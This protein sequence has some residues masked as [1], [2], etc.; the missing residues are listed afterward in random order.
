MLSLVVEGRLGDEIVSSRYG[1]FFDWASTSPLSEP[2]RRA[3]DD[4]IATA[5][6]TVDPPS[7][8]RAATSALDSLR[9]DLCLLLHADQG[10]AVVLGRSVSELM[11]LV[12]HGLPFAAKRRELVVT[13][14]DHPASTMAWVTVSHARQLRIRVAPSTPLGEVDLEW[15]HENVTERTAAMCVTHVSHLHGTRQPLKQIIELARAEGA[16]TIVDGAQAVG[17]IDVDLQELDADVYLGV[18]RKALLAP[19]GTAFLV[20][21]RQL[22]DRLQPL[23]LSTRA[24]R[25]SQSTSSELGITLAP[26]PER[27]EFNVPDLAGLHALHGSVSALLRIGVRAV[28][29]H[30]RSLLPVIV[31]SLAEHGYAPAIT[32]LPDGNAGIMTFAVPE[33]GN[34]RALQDRLRRD[35]FIIAADDQTIRVSLHLA[36]TLDTTRQLAELLLE[37]AQ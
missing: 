33:N 10:Q 1:R 5:D 12:A 24:A 4:L 27:F 26:V 20:A 17:R 16:L 6:G 11:G 35:G 14:L 9:A 21:S 28:A 29:E 23:L 37:G 25:L 8:L 36:N 15:L 31:E 7:A 13:A 30:V 22:L 19:I 18:G 2:A 3:R 34:G 32:P